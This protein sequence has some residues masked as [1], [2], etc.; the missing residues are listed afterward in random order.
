MREYWCWGARS[1]G[2]EKADQSCKVINWI[3]ETNKGNQETL[4]WY[5]RNNIQI[6]QLFNFSTFL[7]SAPAFSFWNFEG[8]NYC[9]YYQLHSIVNEKAVHITS[10]CDWFVTEKQCFK[11]KSIDFR[12]IISILSIHLNCLNKKFR[13]NIILRILF[14]E[15]IADRRLRFRIGWRPREG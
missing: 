11:F 2:T 10:R 3:F 5:L 12:L 8:L 1:F 4:V 9:G 15:G 6:W 7:S 13:L 14:K